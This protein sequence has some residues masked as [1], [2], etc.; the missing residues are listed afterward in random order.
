MR[1]CTKSAPS[2]QAPY[3]S[4][5]D[6]EIEELELATEQLSL[7]YTQPPDR[8]PS[9]HGCHDSVSRSAPAATKSVDSGKSL[10]I[11]FTGQ[12]TSQRL[13]AF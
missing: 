6:F 2:R 5:S 3:A 13:S 4:V 11:R 10:I 8:Q 7:P 12:T 9:L 1:S